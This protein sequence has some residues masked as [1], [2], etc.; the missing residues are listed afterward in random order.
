MFPMKKDILLYIF[1]L[2]LVQGLTEFLP[3]SSSGHLLVIQNVYVYKNNTVLSDS[4]GLFG[5]LTP[6]AGTLVA[7]LAYLF[8]VWFRDLKLFMTLVFTRQHPKPHH[9]KKRLQFWTALLITT[10]VSGVFGLMFHNTVEQSFASIKSAII[11]FSITGTV[12]LFGR[13]AFQTGRNPWKNWT[14]VISVGLFVGIA[15]SIA[16]WPGV[17]RSGM[18]ITACLFAGLAP[19]EAFQYSFLTG[20]ALI[21][22]AWIVDMIGGF[23]ADVGALPVPVYLFGFL[24]SALVGWLG[25][26]WTE[27]WT[28][29]WKLHWLGY[30]CIGLA[31]FLVLV[32]LFFPQ[33]FA[34]PSF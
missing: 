30:Y 32:V 15:Q 10:F 8:P 25:L 7:A 14:S 29:G 28:T 17:S 12:L 9:Y 19:L 23:S 27:K 13:R 20:S 26:K 22:G 2:A 33:V 1:V 21:A 5:D 3:I 34:F 11:G 6:H 16:L 4:W 31:L 24:I 18:T